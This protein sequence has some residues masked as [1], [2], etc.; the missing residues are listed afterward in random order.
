MLKELLYI[1]GSGRSGST[2][3]D[4][5]LNT[6]PDIAAL[7]EVH[8]FSM[9]INSKEEAHKCTC[10]ASVGDCHFWMGVVEGL[11]KKGIDPGALRTTW[12]WNHQVGVDEDG[13]NIKEKIAP[14]NILHRVNLF[15]VLLAAGFG[16]VAVRFASCFSF[17]NRG[18]KIFEDSWLL[19]KAVSDVSGKNVIVDGTKSPGRLMGLARINP[20]NVPIKVVYLCRDGRAVVHA[21][22]KRQRV[23]MKKAAKIWR[24]EHLKIQRALR[25][26]ELPFIKVKYEEL[27]ENTDFVMK[28]VFDFSSAEKSEINLSFREGSHSLGGNPM[29]K[30]V[31]EDRIIINEK[32]K[33][34]LSSKDLKV[35][36]K[37]AGPM[38]ENL[39][40]KN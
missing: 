10:G 16:A 15:N 24:L 35:F 11:K 27:C 7:G 37:I 19:Y 40:Y 8:R 6:N 39:G 9:N 23:S 1:T 25:V 28:K 26:S 30:R 4:M 18:K 3:L 22:M 5:L 32:W 31:N 2:L 36:N 38:N 14:S 34:E 33:S 12:D 29:R 13:I 21:R 17:L 20:E